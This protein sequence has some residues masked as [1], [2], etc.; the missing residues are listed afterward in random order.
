M[1]FILVGYEEIV[2]KR[3]HFLFGRLFGYGCLNIVSK[4]SRSVYEDE[5]E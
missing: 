5:S 4:V 1:D 2:T 3:L